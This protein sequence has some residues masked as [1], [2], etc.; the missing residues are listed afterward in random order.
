M[1][2]RWIVNPD[3][4]LPRFVKRRVDK[5]SLVAPADVWNYVRSGDYP[6]DIGTQEDCV[7]NCNCTSRWIH[8]PDFLIK[9]ELEPHPSVVVRRLC[10][11]DD[12]SSEECTG[13]NNLNNAAPSLYVLK[14]RLAYN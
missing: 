13:L 5:I 8:D 14:K 3:L 6:A 9:K 11:T 12:L 2:L 4:H 1:V 7:K 10:V